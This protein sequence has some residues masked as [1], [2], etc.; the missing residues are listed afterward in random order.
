MAPTDSSTRPKTTE[1]KAKVSRNAYKG[2][3]R[4]RPRELARVLRQLTAL[5][6]PSGNRRKF[7]VTF[8]GVLESRHSPRWRSMRAG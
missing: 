5:R 7:I 3:T 4:A 8:A 2:G 1:G 6:P